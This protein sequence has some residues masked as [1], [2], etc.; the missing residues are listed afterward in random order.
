[1][2][3]DNNDN[4]NNDYGRRSMGI[5]YI[6]WSIPSFKIM[7]LLVPKKEIFNWQCDQ[8]N[9][10]VGLYLP[11]RQL[12]KTRFPMTGLIFSPE[13]KSFT[14]ILTNFVTIYVTSLNNF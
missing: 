6:L 10:E 9:L 5:L 2:V 3:D 14:I 1:M 4:D 13:K 8:N 12:P 7:Q 11:G